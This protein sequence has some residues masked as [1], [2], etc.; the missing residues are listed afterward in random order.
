MPRLS[1]ITGAYNANECPHFR[2]SIESILNQSFTDFEFIICDD[3]STDNT[4][5]ILK[6]YAQADSRLIILQ[7]NKNLGLA[8]TLNRCIEAA[9]GEYIARHDCDDFSASTR[10]EKQISYLDSHPK[11]AILGT[12]I[13]LF[14]ENGVQSKETMPER[15]SPKDFCFNNP[16]KHGTVIFKRSALLR[17]GGYSTEKRCVRNEDY[18]LF[19]R[20]QLFSVGENLSEPLYYFFE[21]KKAMKRRK[22]RYR[23]NETRVRFRGFK[24]LGLMPRAFPYVIKPLI[25]GLIPRFLLKRIQIRRRAK[26]NKRNL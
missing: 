11:T 20:M 18:D 22:Y 17:A 5:E 13:Y 1:V 14:D 2:K 10:F 21:D 25:V 26:L 24:K 19:M 4:L 15:V 7:N 3:G 9:Q 6:K 16:Y 12:S 23:I 8:P